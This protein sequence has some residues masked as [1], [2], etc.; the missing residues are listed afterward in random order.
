MR[1]ITSIDIHKIREQRR[2]LLAQNPSTIQQESK[3]PQFTQMINRLDKSIQ[4]TMLRIAS[5]STYDDTELFK[6]YSQIPETNE[7]N[8]KDSLEQKIETWEDISFPVQRLC[9]K[10]QIKLI[11]FYSLPL[12]SINNSIHEYNIGFVLEFEL[13]SS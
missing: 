12:N 2:R 3:L 7:A 13:I 10:Y 5:N 11:K 9:E 4:E 6:A 8:Q 1:Y